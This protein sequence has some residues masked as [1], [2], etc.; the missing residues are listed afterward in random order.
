MNCFDDNNI[1]FLDI[2]TNKIDTDL[3]YKPSQTG[4]YSSFNSSPPWNYKTSWIKSP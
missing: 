1:H 2:T 3:Y 4:Q